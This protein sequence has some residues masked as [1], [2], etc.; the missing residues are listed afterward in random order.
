MKLDDAQ[1]ETHRQI[2]KIIHQHISTNILATFL[3]PACL[4]WQG[5]R[6]EDDNMAAMVAHLPHSHFSPAQH[7]AE[8]VS[9]GE[10]TRVWRG[11]LL[12]NQ[13]TAEAWQWYQLGPRIS[14]PL[15]DDRAGRRCDQ[16]THHLH[17]N[18]LDEPM[19]GRNPGKQG[20]SEC[21][22]QSYSDERSLKKHKN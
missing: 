15:T 3:H 10:V 4:L 14:F 12:S 7:E 2:S 20:G 17:L 13:K 19:K 22:N 21:E 1:T 18:M 16:A 6:V 5:H 8:A 9:Q 11:S